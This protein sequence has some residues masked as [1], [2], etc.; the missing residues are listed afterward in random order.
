M[1]FCRNVLQQVNM[2]QLTES[3]FW[4]DVILSRWQSFHAEKCCHLGC[5]HAAC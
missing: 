1:K 3:D 5:A 2:H 4:F